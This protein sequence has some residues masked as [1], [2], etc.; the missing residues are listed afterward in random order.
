MGF[1]IRCRESFT[2]VFSYCMT[3]KREIWKLY[4]P[5]TTAILDKGRILEIVSIPLLDNMNTFEIFNILNIP[6]P[7]KDPAVP[8]NKLP[9]MVAWYRLETS[10]IAV[11]LAW[12]KYILLTTTE[13][14]HC[15][16]PL[17]H[18]CDV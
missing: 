10:S 15:T 4:Q 12:M 8:T 9:S 6:V 7:V 17:Q 3:Q 5:L 2:T 18:Y 11:Y 16:S 1:A 14:E 13:Q